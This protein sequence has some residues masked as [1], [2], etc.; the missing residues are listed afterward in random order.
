VKKG[1]VVPHR[2]EIAKMGSTGRSTG[3]HIHYEIM[4]NGK[5]VDPAKFFEAG[6]LVFKG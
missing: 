3:P 1:D 6:R 5:P 4:I 2:F